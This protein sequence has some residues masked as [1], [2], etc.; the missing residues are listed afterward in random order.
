MPDDP[1]AFDLSVVNDTF[2]ATDV[3]NATAVIDRQLKLLQKS[4]LKKKRMIVKLEDN[5]SDNFTDEQNQ[6][7]SVGELFGTF[8]GDGA[9]NFELRL[10]GEGT[11]AT[12]R[13]STTTNSSDVKNAFNKVQELQEKGKNNMM[14]FLGMNNVTGLSHA[15][16]APRSG[17]NVLDVDEDYSVEEVWNKML[18]LKGLLFAEPDLE[19]TALQSD[20][21]SCSLVA[22]WGY[23]QTRA[24][25]AVELLGLNDEQALEEAEVLVLV[26]DSGIDFNHPA[27]QDRVYVNIEE[28]NGVD[29]VDDD[30]NGLVDDIRGWN[31]ASGTNN[32][33][34][35]NGHGTHVSGIIAANPSSNPDF[36]GIAPN[37]VILPCR[38]TDEGQTG[39]VS[40]AIECLEYGW[41]MGV[42]ITSNSWGDEMLA[43]RSLREIFEKSEEEDTLAIV[44][45]GNDGSSNDGPIDERTFPASFQNEIIMAVAAIDAAGRLSSIS[46]FGEQNVDLGAPGENI[47]STTPNNG[48]STMRGTS[49]ATPFVTGAAALLLGACKK[50]GVSCTADQ[51]KSILIDSVEHTGNLDDLVLSE[52]HLNVAN[53]A[54]AVETLGLE[55][56]QTSFTGDSME[57]C[58]S[59]ARGR[60]S[61]VVFIALLCLVLWTLV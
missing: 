2:E 39:T 36:Q 38:F 17:I 34:D 15:F 10:Q 29:G 35:D 53:A 46:N 61:I 14:D 40:A 37:A 31:F 60:G 41:L 59:G 28:L 13:R 51:I 24:S 7:S 30:G 20:V 3:G 47:L 44:A 43:T 12:L 45:A 21:S 19:L 4:D 48:Y 25:E 49:M 22:D 16:Y 52:G 54:R 33:M 27:L 26:V 58:E 57:L 6:Y 50:Q 55:L 8:T 11:S 9:G 42:D 23:R 32:T 5:P 56:N 1:F 18:P